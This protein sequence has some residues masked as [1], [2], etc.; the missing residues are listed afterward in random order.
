MGYYRAKEESP[1]CNL[2]S[3][4]TS[5]RAVDVYIFHQDA[6]ATHHIKKQNANKWL[7]TTGK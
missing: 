4:G 5:F 1:Y 6:N 3:N 7:R 2:Q